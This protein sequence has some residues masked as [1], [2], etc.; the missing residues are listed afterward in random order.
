MSPMMRGKLTRNIDYHAALVDFYR[1]QVKKE[2]SAEPPADTRR[3]RASHPS[4]EE[5]Q[6]KPRSVAETLAALHDSV[7]EQLNA[8]L[9]ADPPITAIDLALAA[10]RPLRRVG[11]TAPTAGRLH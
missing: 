5:A 1:E 8:V 3:S 7:V 11:R 4:E 6:E 2:Q 10:K 9:A